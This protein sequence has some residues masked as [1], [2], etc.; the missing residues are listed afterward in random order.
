M[1]VCAVMGTGAMP[2]S[3]VRRAESYNVEGRWFALLGEEADGEEREVVVVK[4]CRGGGVG[5]RKGD[6]QRLLEADGGGGVGDDDDDGNLVMKRR[7][8]GC[9]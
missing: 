2:S 4:A 9:N 5:I 7:A 6:D 1:M 8:I 3:R